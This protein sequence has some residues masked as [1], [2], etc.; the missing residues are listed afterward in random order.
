MLIR[1]VKE[2]IRRAPQRKAM[3]VLAIALGSAVATS[4]LGVMLSIGD[5]VN[6]ELRAAGANI[7]VT[8]RA[9][10]LTAGVGGIT[11]T[12]SSPER[13]IKDDDVLQV[14]K[15]FW[16]F[17]VTSF[18]PSLAARDGAMQVQGVW[19]N[20]P[21]KDPATSQ[22]LTTGAKTLNPNWIV[23][24]RWA[25]DAKAECMAGEAAARRAGWK[26]GQDVTVLGAPCKITGII[27]A[28]DE[29]DDRVLAPLARVQELT[30]RVGLV[31]RIDVAA[32]TKPEDDFARRDP[33]TMTAAEF[34]LWNCTNYVSSIAHELREAIP[35]TDARAVRRVA[36]SEGRILDKVGGLMG[37]ITL[38]AL[39]SAGL[40]V[41]SLTATTMLE[42]R[43]E[44]AIMQAI[45]AGRWLVAAMLS[46]EIAL[47][48]LLGGICGALGGVWLAH[49]VGR[50]VFH[51]AVEISPALPLIITAAAIL[52]ALLGAAQPLRQTLRLEPAVI[53]R[54]G[55]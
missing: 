51:D 39:I 14:R 5:K 31:D 22:I 30:N 4:M 34:E 7:V 10:A 17:N 23:A 19:F 15:I 50:T 12:A 1:F 20:H 45:G 13:Y 46:I 37:L 36:D 47:V 52:V 55:I 48:G 11:T 41:W 43:G 53:L 35:G 44:I 9:A 26:T 21:Y 32:L 24:G 6:R 40:T 8:K 16:A 3:I 33:S 28:G 54:E 29:T 2:S 38:A 49:L 42:R 18:S 25:D 27:S